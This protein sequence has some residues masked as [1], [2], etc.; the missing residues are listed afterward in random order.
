MWRVI[1]LMSLLC[2]SCASVDKLAATLEAREIK[3]CIRA[4]GSYGPFVGFTVL[5]VTGGASIDD[6][7]DLW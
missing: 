5:S 6:C 4:S 7:R 1:A 3:S 2:T